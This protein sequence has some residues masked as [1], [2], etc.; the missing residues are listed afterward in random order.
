MDTKGLGAIGALLLVGG[1]LVV[2]GV[3]PT[4]S[5]N[6]AVQENQ[7]TEATV[8]STDVAVKT[9]EDGDKSYRPVVTYEYTLDGETHRNDNV[10]P[11][12]FTRWDGSRAW[13]ERIARQYAPGDRVTVHYR[14]GEPG[15][16]YLRNDGW[17]DAWWIGGIAIL[18][19][20]GGGAGLIKTGF[21]RRKQR[22]LMRDT[23]TEDVESIA[24]G[25]S[26]LKGSALA[27]D[28]D[29][30][31][32]PFSD[33]ECVVAEYEVE[34]YHEDDDGGS[35]NTVAS[36]VVH[37]PFSLDDG[38]G[39]V[40]VEPHD[41]AT[42]DIDPADRETIRVDSSE[43]GPDPVQRFV[44]RMDD[45][46][47]P[48][49]AAGSEND[50]RYHQNLIRDKESVYVYGTAQPRGG[51]H[52]GGSNP[53]LLVIRRVAADDALDDT[54]FLIS[55]DTEAGLVNRR[56]WAGLRIPAG[57]GFIVLGFACVLVVFGP[58]AGLEIPALF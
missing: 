48:A 24:V 46:S 43:R 15:H 12:G 56:E 33:D 47:Y 44:E 16:A 30:F 5:H 55:D 4:V 36:G 10:F 11:G 20:V 32:A 26:E 18:V 8:Q 7:P 19:L 2:M 21:T 14:P 38:T 50:R 39:R 52:R 17:P 6:I 58:L 57:G 1:F 35:W 13:A 40:L 25:P 41:D 34:Q 31:P 49:D 37:T 22:T 51:D 27:A 28:G 23:P 9:D 42:F 45:V 54:M 3:V 53:D 29:P